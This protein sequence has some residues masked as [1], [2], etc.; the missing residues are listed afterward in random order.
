[1]TEGG[2]A[3]NQL[4]RLGIQALLIGVLGACSSEAPESGA[5]EAPEAWF[6]ERG[7]LA[8][9]D[10]THRTGATGA[11]LF[12]EMMGGAVALL[13][14]DA[15]GDLDLFFGQSGSLVSP[16]AEPDGHRLYRNIG[17]GKFEDATPGS[18]VDVGG[19]AMGVSAADYDNDGRTDLYITNVGENK[20]LHNDGGGHFSDVTSTAG[21][22]GKVWSTSSAFVDYDGDGDLDLFVVNY[23][24]W[25]LKTEKECYEAS[26]QRTYCGPH[27][28]NAPGRDLLFRN[29]GNGGFTDVSVAAGLSA[30]F[31]NGLGVVAGDFNGDD[32]PDFFVANDRTDDQLWI[33]QGDGTFHDD[34][35]LAGCAVDSNGT[36]RAGMGVDTGDVDDDG[37]LD[38]I[39]VNLHGEDDGYYRNEGRFFVEETTVAGI[40]LTSRAY[41]R[42]GV[43]F[44][45]F[46]NDGDL[47]LYQANGRVTLVATHFSE[48]PFAEPNVL[49]ERTAQGKWA[50]VEPRGG[51]AE[52]LS[53]TS[54]G[55]AF[56]DLDNDGGIDVVVTN[57]DA[58]PHVLFNT[59]RGRGHWL[60][61]RVLERHGSDAIGARV[62]LPEG[63]TRRRRDVRAASSY[64]SSSDPR[65]HFGL[66]GPAPV[67]RLEVRW[68]DGTVEIFG[69]FDVDSIV[70]LNRGA[71]RVD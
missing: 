56:G 32:L 60:I 13:D 48:D 41:T 70:T 50:P 9:V 8:G 3:S 44:E 47:D 20:L 10:F 23:V 33:N 42:F 17:E 30:G 37:D 46:D 26:G 7:Q 67:E 15:D 16:G 11:F 71:G 21:V 57:R 29:E 36:A 39:V 5:G 31:G 45:D 65:V 51:V 28:Y 25:S 1:M 58:A 62:F 35:Y 19:Y 2:R 22:G 12:P 6:E 43:G 49:L 55:A 4:P 59:Q 14:F 68:P 40:G 52:E 53:F 18:G 38:L 24:R 54:R 64:C 34:A 66:M 63:P 27:S 69:P 61:A